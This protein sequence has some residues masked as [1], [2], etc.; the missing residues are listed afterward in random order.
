MKKEYLITGDVFIAASFVT[1]ILGGMFKL[2]GINV[3]L[4]SI[5]PMSLL[6]FSYWALLFSI[7]LSLID[8]AK[9]SAK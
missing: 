2:I 8:I 4:W 7:A 9:K 6:K 5:T 1:F 3:I